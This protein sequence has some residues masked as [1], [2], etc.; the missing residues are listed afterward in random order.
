MV[1]F[2]LFFSFSTLL[3]VLRIDSP[4]SSSHTN[5]LK[6][7]VNPSKPCLNHL[8]V[9]LP[10]H[11]FYGQQVKVLQAGS[12][13]TMNWF[14]FEHPKHEYF[15]YR[16][17]QSWLSE[18]PPPEIIPSDRTNTQFVLS[19][20]ALQKLAKILL[21]SSSLS[22]ALDGLGSFQVSQLSKNEGKFL[23]EAQPEKDN[24]CSSFSKK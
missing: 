24:G 14:L 6:A 3:R 16:I 13:D 15:H 22:M 18:D 12:T 23:K 1:S 17:S 20:S 9:I 11:P 10:G 4:L 19:F 5:I 2:E 21:P 8:Y 7:T